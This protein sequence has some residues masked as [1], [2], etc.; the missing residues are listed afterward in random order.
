MSSP[1]AMRRPPQAP[2]KRMP[3][4]WPRELR[5]KPRWKVPCCPSR[6]D[7][8]VMVS[9]GQSSFGN[10]GPHPQKPRPSSGVQ[11]PKQ[12]E[13]QP[14]QEQQQHL[15]LD[16]K[17]LASPGLPSHG[18]RCWS[19]RIKDIADCRVC[20]HSSRLS[21][22]KR[23]RV[24]SSSPLRRPRCGKVWATVNKT[25][26]LWRAF[27]THSALKTMPKGCCREARRRRKQYR[28][29][30]FPTAVGMEAFSS[31]T[32][33]FTSKRAAATLA[34][35]AQASS[36]CGLARLST[37]E[38]LDEFEALELRDPRFLRSSETSSSLEDLGLVLRVVRLL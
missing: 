18:S 21:G 2:T 23:L 17:P 34:A 27:R 19:T 36:R 22:C 5:C 15:C 13:Q 9:S 28:P 37:D 30:T 12:Q 32:A 1:T 35:S 6:T 26:S 25:E 31:A 14:L 33:L 38:P 24:M 16:E 20:V 10:G 3:R 4:R 29:R 11:H 7:G 8:L